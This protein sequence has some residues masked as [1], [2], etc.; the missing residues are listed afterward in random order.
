[1]RR[2]R[3]SK[4]LSRYA[5]SVINTN[6]CSASRFFDMGSCLYVFGQEEKAIFDKGIK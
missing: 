5:A 3:R 4:R 1:M 6:I 2:E